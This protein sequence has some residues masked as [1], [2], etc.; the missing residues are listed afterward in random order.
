MSN[1]SP[2]TDQV[3]GLS[4][5]LNGSLRVSNGQSHGGDMTLTVLGCGEYVPIT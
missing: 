3:D 4:D 2:Y 5:R 1:M